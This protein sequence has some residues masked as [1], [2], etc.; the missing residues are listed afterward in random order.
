MSPCFVLVSV[1]PRRMSARA[2]SSSSRVRAPANC[3]S[4][5]AISLAERTTRR[6]AEFQLL[7]PG[8]R[9]FHIALDDLDDIRAVADIVDRL[10]AYEG[11]SSIRR[12]GRRA[13]L[14]HGGPESSRNKSIAVQNVNAQ[15][16]LPGRRSIRTSRLPSQRGGLWLVGQLDPQYRQET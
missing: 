9:E 16:S 1:M 11:Q 2:S 8:P 5:I 10:P 6:K 7:P 15:T 4:R 13:G 12:T 3:L 14:A